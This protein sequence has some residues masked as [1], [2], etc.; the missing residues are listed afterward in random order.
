[1]ATWQ[2]Q[3]LLKIHMQQRP[4]GLFLSRALSSN[5]SNDGQKSADKNQQG[6]EDGTKKGSEEDP[7][8]ELVLTPGEKVVAYSRLGM[9]GGIAVFAGFCAYYIGKELFPT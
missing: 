2:Q 3:Q 9:W 5:S 4:L 7:G 1:L 8:S 6:S